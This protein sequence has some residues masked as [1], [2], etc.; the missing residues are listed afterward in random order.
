MRAQRTRATRPSRC[1]PRQG[2]GG[3]SEEEKAWVAL[4]VLVNPYKYAHVSEAEA[5]EMKHDEGYKV[6]GGV[7]ERT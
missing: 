4:D 1:S 7:Y 3:R 2:L 5:E 6:K